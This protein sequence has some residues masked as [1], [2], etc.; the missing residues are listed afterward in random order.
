MNCYILGTILWNISSWEKH[1]LFLTIVLI[2]I[3]QLNLFLQIVK[4]YI[5]VSVDMPSDTDW[6]ILHT[7]NLVLEFG[8]DDEFNGL[9]VCL[10]AGEVMV[11]VL[12]FKRDV[13]L[14]HGIL[15]VSNFSKITPHLSRLLA[16]KNGHFSQQL[17]TLKFLI[18]KIK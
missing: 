16:F 5:H 18:Q 12:D 3:T 1:W 15:C 7:Y 17:L 4:F 8:V 14:W 13:G 11:C 6:L 9:F 2:A 10:F